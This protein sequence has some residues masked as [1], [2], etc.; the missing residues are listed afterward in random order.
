MQQPTTT[1]TKHRLFRVRFRDGATV[2]T[3]A[4]NSLQAE[5]NARRLRP[6]FVET[7]RLVKGNR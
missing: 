7:V 1:I 5:Q 6:G 2:T 4:A 3:A